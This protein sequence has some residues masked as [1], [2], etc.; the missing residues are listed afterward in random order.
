MTIKNPIPYELRLSTREQ[1][2]TMDKRTI[3]EFGIDGFT[4]MEM[5]GSKAASIIKQNEGVGKNG[6]FFCGKGN[7]AGDAFVVARYLCSQEHHSVTLVLTSDENDLSTD[8]ARNFA[9]LK[10]IKEDGGDVS[11]TDDF[12]SID[13]RNFDYIVDGLIGTGLSSELRDPYAKI[14][15][16]INSIN[17]PTYSLDIPTG[18]DCDSGKILGSAVEANHTLTF[19][20]NKRGFYLNAGRKCSGQIHVVRL[21]FP[22]KFH[23]YDATLID[24]RWSEVLPPFE[25]KA[26]HKYQKGTVHIVAGS[27]GLTGAAI[28]SAKSAWSSGAGAVILYVPKNL[29]PIYEITLPEIIKIP[30]GED[31]DTHFKPSHVDEILTKLES[32]EGPLLIGPG[33]G[34]LQETQK[35]VVNLLNKY[36]AQV[37]IDADALLTWD[38]LGD[39]KK[40]IKK[41]WLITPHIGELKKSIGQSFD[42]DSA[43]LEVCSMLAANHSV[44]IL[45]K[46]DPTMFINPNREKFFTGYDTKKFSRAGFGDILAGTITSYLSV[47]ENLTHSVI[48]ALCKGYAKSKNKPAQ[49]IFEPRHL[50]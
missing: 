50:L 6:L 48:A 27:Q 38:K 41:N 2:R 30:V 28:M 3:E 29:L 35:F 49:E 46:G 26:D 9:L 1:C 47:K 17:L 37:V 36:S 15:D 42:D 40:E 22:N 34:V 10:Q 13:Q 7:N 24:E 21:P 18:L 4:L 19:G 16:C 23:E 33:I 8:A 45:S 25:R 14:V 43:R 12:Q 32:K 31:S 39:I 44:S 20:A 11:F 5:A